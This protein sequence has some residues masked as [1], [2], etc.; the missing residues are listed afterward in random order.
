MAAML[1][2]QVSVLGSAGQPIAATMLARTPP[3]GKEKLSREIRLAFG[4]IVHQDGKN[5]PSVSR[6]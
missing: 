2:R 3:R 1:T 4:R 5:R 6:H